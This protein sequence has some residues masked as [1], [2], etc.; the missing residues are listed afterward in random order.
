MGIKVLLETN[1]KEDLNDLRFKFLD[2]TVDLIP[3]VEKIE[4]PNDSLVKTRKT[5][6]CGTRRFISIAHYEK[7]LDMTQN[8]SILDEDNFWKDKDYYYFYGKPKRKSNSRL[9]N[10]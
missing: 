2:L 8:S 4:V 6:L 5:I 9:P 1:K 7:N 10:A 3:P